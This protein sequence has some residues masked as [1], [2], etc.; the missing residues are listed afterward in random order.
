MPR[1][2]STDMATASDGPQVHEGPLARPI[3]DGLLSAIADDGRTAYALAK[4]ADLDE[5]IVRR[6]IR[7]EKTLA[8]SSIAKL[9]DVL[10]LKVVRESQGQ[11]SEA[12][13][14]YSPQPLVEGLQSAITE[15]G[16]SIYALAKAADVD[17]CSLRIFA[18]QGKGLG[19]DPADNVAIVVGLKVVRVARPEVPRP[20]PPPQPFSD[21]LRSAI[22]DRGLSAYALA[23]ASGI[24][25][26]AIYRLIRHEA[27]IDLATA[28]RLAVPLGLRVVRESQQQG[29]E[30]S[31]DDSAQPFSDVL[32][33]AI[34]TD[35]RSIYALAN[36]SGIDGDALYRFVHGETD[37]RLASADKV[38]VV[39]GLKVVRVAKARV[40]QSEVPPD[41]L[42]APL[43]TALRSAIADRGLSAYELA[44]RSGVTTPSIY[45]LRK[46]GDI[47]YFTAIKL[48]NALGLKLEP[49]WVRSDAPPHS[50][51][52]PTL[53]PRDSATIEDK[54]IDRKAK[55]CPVELQGEG[56]P[57]RVHEGDR[58]VETPKMTGVAYKV[59]E[60]IVDRF[61]KGG[62]VLPGELTRMTDSTRPMRLFIKAL[63]RDDFEPVRRMIPS[64]KA[65][66]NKVLEIVD[67]GPRT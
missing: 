56:F 41:N 17:Y 14:D 24:H 31:D 65:G 25:L 45:S 42:L 32:R 5:R 27:S 58:T 67:A 61:H 35:G 43:F 38:A 49:A 3:T 23:K 54:S 55:R 16:L 26:G 53:A 64:W 19:L 4:A 8:L 52:G 15:S 18:R 7:R 60:T 44:R 39:V 62:G 11:G 10:G 30:A 20:E 13:D 29:T 21:G 66:R 28:D 12:G 51:T 59:L 36:A 37:L 1:P 57:I 34:V 40:P 33:S 48:A 47:K 22:A 6:F 46:G 50:P 2:E 9:F 63:E